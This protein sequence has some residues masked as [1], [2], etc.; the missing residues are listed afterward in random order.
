MTARKAALV[1]DQMRRSVPGTSIFAVK[2]TGSM[3][4][5][6]DG[7]CLLLTEPAPYKELAIGDIVVFRH[8]RT[9]AHIVHRI[10]EVRSGG[11]WTKGDHNDRM[12]DEL[13]TASN[14]V[15]RIYGILYT[16]RNQQNQTADAIT[17]S[18]KLSALAD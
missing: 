1:A 14:Y 4:P 2:A 18:I 11:Y 5:L 12:D 7:N 17:S 13:V 9:G 8:A 3:R 15:G 6:F 16:E 10:L